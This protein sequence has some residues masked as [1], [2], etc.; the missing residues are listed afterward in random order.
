MAVYEPGCHPL[1]IIWIEAKLS[2]IY[3]VVGDKL[4]HKLPFGLKC[5]ELFV[6]LYSIL[7]NLSDDM[8][9]CYSKIKIEFEQNPEENII[10]TE[11]GQYTVI[12]TSSISI[13]IYGPA[14]SVYCYMDQLGQYT[15]IW[16]SSITK[17][18][19]ENIN[20]NIQVCLA[21]LTLIA[22]DKP[23]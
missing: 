15:V 23:I 10:L 18:N 9:F 7:A 22:N 13:L 1:N 8:F 6:I 3:Y 17:T 20:V 4:V 21:K 14:R 5:H 16:T 2:S 19:R 11:L 12:W